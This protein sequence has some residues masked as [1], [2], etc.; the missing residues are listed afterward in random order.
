LQ[1]VA[2]ARLSDG[3]VVARG[4]T[5]RLDYRRAGGRLAASDAGAMIYPEP[6]T[7]LSTFGA[8]HLVAPRLQGDVPARRG[9]ASAGVRLD[10]ARGDS[11][12]TDHV[13]L[14]GDLLKTDAH[15]WAQGPGYRVEGN[16]LLARTDGAFVQLTSGAT[17]QLQA[18]GAR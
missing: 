17:G 8:L 10:A 16:G 1:G 12:R 13:Q 3:R 15:V 9:V 5:E 6:G 4:T 2:F 7:G 18:G 11:A 14:E